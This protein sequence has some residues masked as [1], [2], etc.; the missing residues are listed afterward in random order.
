[1]LA[2]ALGVLE[3]VVERPYDYRPT[4][5]FNAKASCRL[6]V[7]QVTVTGM[8]YSNILILLL[9]VLVLLQKWYNHKSTTPQVPV[10]VLV[11][12]QAE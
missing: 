10:L 12:V 11:P 2:L 6:P 1:M 4:K 3:P 5:L 8:Y 9:V 7:A